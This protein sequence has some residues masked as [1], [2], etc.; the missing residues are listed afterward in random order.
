MTRPMRLALL[1]SALLPGPVAAAEAPINRLP[2][3]SG[4]AAPALLPAALPSPAAAELQPPPFR[5]AVLACPVLPGTAR[6]RLRW[7]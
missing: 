6:P 2:Q 5:R 1:L 3:A 7:T 4:C